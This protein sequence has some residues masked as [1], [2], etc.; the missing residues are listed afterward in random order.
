MKL[1]KGNTGDKAALEPGSPPQVGSALADRVDGERAVRGCTGDHRA[2]TTCVGL[3][4]RFRA[5][6]ATFADPLIPQRLK[7]RSG[8]GCLGQDD[9]YRIH[10]CQP[11]RSKTLV[12]TLSEIIVKYSR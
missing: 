7:G 1:A 11:F 10:H 3:T 5:R 4:C 6:C 2:E 12:E 9:E 8:L